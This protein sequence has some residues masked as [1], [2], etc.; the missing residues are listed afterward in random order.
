MSR[1][2]HGGRARIGAM[3]ITLR[4]ASIADLDALVPL[5]CGYRAFYG[6][7]SEPARARD[8]LAARLAGG[9]STVLLACAEDRAIGFAQL[10][11]SWSSLAMAPLWLLSDLY[12][13][14]AHRALGAGRALL[15]ACEALGCESGACR[16]QLETQRTNTV[17]QALYTELGWESDDEFVVFTLPL[18]A[19]A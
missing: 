3:S 14:P 13:D 19:P 12:V 16:L 18:G 10:F 11:P 2:G 7:D 6:R 5:F 9:E 1:C 4:H 15:E 8:W 17:A